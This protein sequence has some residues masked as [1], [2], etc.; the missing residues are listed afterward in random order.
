MERLFNFPHLRGDAWDAAMFASQ[1]IV[2]TGADPDQLETLLGSTRLDV[3]WQARQ[4]PAFAPVTELFP[5]LR[6]IQASK[7]PA[8]SILERLKPYLPEGAS[9]SPQALEM[10]GGLVATFGEDSWIEVTGRH[11]RPTSALDFSQLYRLYT[12]SPLAEKLTALLGQRLNPTDLFDLERLGSI[13]ARIRPGTTLTPEAGMMLSFWIAAASELPPILA[14]EAPTDWREWIE[15]QL[16]L[17]LVRQTLDQRLSVNPEATSLDLYNFGLLP[18][19]LALLDRAIDHKARYQRAVDPEGQVK[20]DRVDIFRGYLDFRRAGQTDLATVFARAESLFPILQAAYAPGPQR[21]LA[22][23]AEEIVRR[24]PE[25][26]F[27][28]S[29]LSLLLRVTA[30]LLEAFDLPTLER[31]IGIKMDG[32]PEQ[33]L[34]TF[35]LSK[36]IEAPTIETERVLDVFLGLDWILTP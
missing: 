20:L 28:P 9:V 16:P 18:L 24:F 6:A 8:T 36:V 5:L 11:L 14:S 25:K 31:R 12:S 32:N 10:I 15:E 19:V 29:S 35:F 27:E 22:T 21:Q 3:Y 7:I 26:V 4:L 13:V 1:L 30:L 17:P 2:L 34:I 33:L 23:K